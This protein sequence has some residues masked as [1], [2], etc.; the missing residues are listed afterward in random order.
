MTENRKNNI[1]ITNYQK[2][3]ELVFLRLPKKENNEE[4]KK[5]TLD[6]GL[7]AGGYLMMVFACYC[8]IFLSWAIIIRLWSGKQCVN[9]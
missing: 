7:F 3:L 6:D 5:K 4:L 9:N 1:I 2:G 8:F